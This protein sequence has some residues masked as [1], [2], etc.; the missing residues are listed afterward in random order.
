MGD[1]ICRRSGKLVEQEQDNPG[2]KSEMG[3]ALEDT[4]RDLGWLTEFHNPNL[5]RDPGSLECLSRTRPVSESTRKTY[6]RIIREYGTWNGVKYPIPSTPACVAEYLQEKVDVQG[7]SPSSVTTYAAA[8]RFANLAFGYPDPTKDPIAGAV[9]KAIRR[10]AQQ[11]GGWTP[12]ETIPI[13]LA[14]LEAMCQPGLDTNMVREACDRA[15]LLLGFFGGLRQGELSDLCIEQLH[16]TEEGMLIELESSKPHLNDGRGRIVALPSGP[17]NLCPVRAVR[18][19]LAAAQ[20]R[21]GYLFRLVNER[22]LVQKPRRDA[23][24]PGRIAPGQANSIVRRR[25]T[26]AGLTD[27]A[28]AVGSLRAG[29]QNLIGE[30]GMPDSWILRQT[31]LKSANYL[32]RYDPPGLNFEEN[33]AT[34]FLAN[35]RAKERP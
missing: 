4:I 35:L 13:L 24:S 9:I 20:L 19:W 32:K 2:E 1:D 14:D 23:R 21:A 33:A 34:L 8:L 28:Y 31:G 7:I 12:K 11:L 15:Y 6:S 29:L 10:D 5:L 25:A 17:E 22:G 26:L 27:S 18:D 3:H 16:E 30:M